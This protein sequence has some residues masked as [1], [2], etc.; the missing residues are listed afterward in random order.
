MEAIIAIPDESGDCSEAVSDLKNLPSTVD[1]A[2][3]GEGGIAVV[4]L[5]QTQL[6]QRKAEIQEQ[7]SE[8]ESEL[9]NAQ[10]RKQ[11]IE[12]DGVT[13]EEEPQIKLLE[14]ITQTRREQLQKNNEMDA[15]IEAE[16]RQK[17]EAKQMNELGNVLHQLKQ[18]SASR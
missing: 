9:Q 10:A 7:S 1:S 17:E 4:A 14:E 8:L 13:A 18:V 12:S 16:L 3:E 2:Q 6:R 15:Q 11:E 5:E